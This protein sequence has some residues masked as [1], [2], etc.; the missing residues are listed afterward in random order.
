MRAVFGVVVEN[1]G[2][3]IG[4]VGRHGA[5]VFVDEFFDVTVVGDDEHHAT[6]LVELFGEAL[7]L[8]VDGFDGND[9]RLELGVV[10]NHVAGG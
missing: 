8:K 6:K 9:T 10:A 5:A 4:G 1:A 7:K 3:G 2:D